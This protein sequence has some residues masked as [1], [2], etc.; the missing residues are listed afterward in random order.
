[1]CGFTHFTYIIDW[2]L[3]QQL[4]RYYYYTCFIDGETKA[5]RLS[6]LLKEENLVLGTLQLKELGI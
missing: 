5:E 6:N 4:G 1:M 2:F 3:H